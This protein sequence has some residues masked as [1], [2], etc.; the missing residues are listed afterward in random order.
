MMRQLS[1]EL[2]SSSAWSLCPKVKMTS[3]C[4]RYHSFK[5]KKNKNPTDYCTCEKGEQEKNCEVRWSNNRDVTVLY[6]VQKIVD[7][8]VNMTVSKGLAY[9]GEAVTDRRPSVRPAATLK[10][11]SW[12][13]A[14][15]DLR[16]SDRSNWTPCGPVGDL[17][18]NKTGE[19][20]QTLSD[21]N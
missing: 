15:W 10:K 19:K 17:S 16:L 7:G 20:V 14:S 11:L 8:V 6:F 4:T 18:R 2:F 1:V 3:V 21:S 9:H 12:T 5:A 13:Q